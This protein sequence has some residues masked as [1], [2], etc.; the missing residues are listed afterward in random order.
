MDLN[1]SWWRVLSFV[2]IILTTVLV[3]I[4]VK[5]WWVPLRTQK[6]LRN[7]GIRG[8]PYKLLY[9][10]TKELLEIKKHA[11]STSSEIAPHDILHVVAPHID[12]WAKRYG[13]IFAYWMG[14]QARIVVNDPDIMKQVLSNKFGHYEKPEPNIELKSLIG[15]G[16]VQ[17]N[18][19]KW[20]RQRRLLNPAFHLESLKSM[21][22]VM[23]VSTTKMLEKWKNAISE[24]VKEIEVLKEFQ[25][26]TS[27]VIAR[28]AFGSSFEEGKHIFDMLGELAILVG[29]SFVK[30]NFPGSR[31]F[32]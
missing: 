5:I 6:F 30:I 1:L 11:Q 3:N 28:T 4:V 19:K 16:L 14:T 25:C 9:G 32:H 31:Y 8:S 15:Y 12:V 18:G 23:A 21:V 7:Q 22:P 26:V 13:K 24:G 27:D 20:A 10:S 29:K 17:A 2:G